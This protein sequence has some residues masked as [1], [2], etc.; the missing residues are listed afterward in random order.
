MTTITTIR[1]HALAPGQRAKLLR[2][3]TTMLRDENVLLS[4]RE[5]AAL[6][7]LQYDTIRQYCHHGR[8]ASKPKQGWQGTSLIS[9]AAMR[10]YL[11]SRKK[12]GRPTKASSGR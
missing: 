1:L 10:A 9:H 5:A 2:L 3:Y 4:A 12:A 7:G 11:A 8:I 6:Y